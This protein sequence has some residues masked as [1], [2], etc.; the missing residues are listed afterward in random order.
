MMASATSGADSGGSGA[1]GVMILGMHRS[2]TSA[3]TRLVNLLGPSVCI[4]DDLLVGTRTNAKGHW[5][6]RSLFRLN[7]RLLAEMEGSWWHPP[8]E[9]ALAEW[10]AGLG[11][12]TFAEARAVFDHA[13]PSEPWVWKDP[14]AC[15]TLGFWRQVLDRPVSA[16]VVYR[17]PFDVARSLERRDWMETEFCLALWVRY[18]R[19]L[20]QQAGGLPV[21]VSNYDEV[22]E[23]PEA[24]SEQ[25]RAFLQGVGMTVEASVD[26]ASVREFIDPDLRH[27]RQDLADLGPT[28]DLYRVMQELTGG[29][30]SFV[31]PRLG[32]EE[33]WVGEQLSS[34]GPAWR[35]T[36][37]PPGVQ[38]R[39]T[40]DRV[41]SLVRRATSFGR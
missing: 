26:P 23:D 5:E 30:A 41:R 33:P 40:G 11:A 36:W 35:S 19:L 15:L 27:S 28:A 37:K 7:D 18:T 29:H 25:A 3:V 1:A 6:S 38:P 39:S 32:G 9:A 14:R 22:L 17:N 12:D 13:H 31:P 10:E 2:G 21:L 16:I 20:L 8:T 34:A 24:F 4:D